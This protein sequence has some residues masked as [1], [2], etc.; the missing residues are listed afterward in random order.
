MRPPYKRTAL[1]S[2]LSLARRLFGDP[3]AQ[4][5]QGQIYALARAAARRGAVRDVL[6]DLAGALEEFTATSR[7]APTVASGATSDWCWSRNPACGAPTAGRT[8]ASRGW[9][10][11]ATTSDKRVPSLSAAPWRAASTS[12]T[13][14][15]DFAAERGLGSSRSLACSQDTG[16]FYDDVH[17]NEAGARLAARA[18]AEHLLARRR[19]RTSSNRNDARQRSQ[20]AGYASLALTLLV[21]ATLVHATAT[22]SATMDADEAV[23]AVEALRRYDDLARGELGRFLGDSY[24]PERW[25]PPVQDHLRWYPIVHS[26]SLLPSFAL[27]GVDDFAARLPS[28]VWLAATC[29]VFHALAK[30]IA[31]RHGDLAGLLAVFLLLAAPNVITF[32]PQCLIETCSLFWAALSLFAYIRYVEDPSA[33]R[34]ACAGAALAGALLTKYDHGAPDRVPGRGRALR[35][36]LHVLVALRSTASLL[37]GLPAVVFAL[38]LAHPDKLQAFRDALC[39]GVR[40]QAGDRAQPRP[41]GCW[42]TPEP[43]RRPGGR[44]RLLLELRRERLRLRAVALY[45]LLAMLLLAARRASSSAT[46]SSKHRWHC[47]WS[48]RS[49][50]LI[51]RIAEAC[52]VATAGRLR[53]WAWLLGTLGALG[54]AL[55]AA[56]VGA[57]SH[58]RARRS[59]S[60]AGVRL[61]A[62]RAGLTRTVEDYAAELVDGMRAALS[63]SAGRSWRCPSRWCCSQP[64]S[65]CLCCGAACRRLDLR[66]APRRWRSSSHLHSPVELS[67]RLAWSRCIPSCTRSPTSSPATRRRARILFAGGWDQLAN[68]SPLVPAHAPRARPA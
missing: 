56:R 47:S 27:L 1:W 36:R 60:A 63:F 62:A 14:L 37:F 33:R 46:T 42:S 22:T 5:P 30:R 31:P 35:R 48:R 12:T 24:F 23:H 52:S 49:R 34:A 20:L 10:V 59:T 26:W 43:G 6:P 15:A 40:L 41:R 45:A 8:R 21:T 4:D 25:Q 68:N 65:H 53:A 29:L 13:A 51:E 44:G 16:A 38:W 9:A 2:T 17:L 55:C 39:T 50:H 66:P 7:A 19:S 64:G 3:R 58:D 18:L 67:R 61:T 54:A 28:I 32:A 57:G 11:S